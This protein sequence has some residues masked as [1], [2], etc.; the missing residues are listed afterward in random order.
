MGPQLPAGLTTTAIPPATGAHAGGALSLPDALEPL[1][2]N[3]PTN[4]LAV[5]LV[6]LALELLMARA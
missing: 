4:V 2:A 6:A 5:L 3:T 1:V